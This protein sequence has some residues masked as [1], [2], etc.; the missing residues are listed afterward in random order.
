MTPTQMLRRTQ[1]QVSFSVPLSIFLPTL[2]SLSLSLSL[3]SSRLVSSRLF[4]VCLSVCYNVSLPTIS[5][6]Y[7]CHFERLLI[8]EVY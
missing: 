7:A 1:Q 3:L 2:P 4:S 8:L 5:Y 6:I